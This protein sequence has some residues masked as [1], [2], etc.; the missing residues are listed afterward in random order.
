MKTMKSLSVSF[1]AIALL[2]FVACQD[3]NRQNQPENS[4]TD[5]ETQTDNE[6]MRDGDMTQGDMSGTENSLYDLARDNNDLTSF[7]QNL[8]TQ[9]ASQ[10][11]ENGAGPYTVFA[12]QDAAYEELSDQDRN[13]ANSNRV[14]A[15]EY[16][17]IEEELTEQELR[18]DVEN[19]DGAYTLTTIHGDQ[20]IVEVEG[21]DVI[22]RDQL[23]NEATIIASN[24]DAFNGIVHIIDGVLRPM[25]DQQNQQGTTSALQVDPEG[26]VT[27]AVDD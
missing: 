6:L 27:S 21:D 17:V 11:L 18:T 15:L 8:N 13:Q 4:M 22:L 7:S 10:T 1:I 19:S 23:G 26:T 14:A 12:P 5:M 2:G 20:I 16:L 9:E 3:S 24:D 25:T